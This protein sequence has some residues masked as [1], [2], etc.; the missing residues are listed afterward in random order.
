M[1]GEEK[2]RNIMEQYG[3][4]MISAISGLLVIGLVFTGL[5]PGTGG[6]LKTIGKETVLFG[7]AAG[8]MASEDN[9]LSFLKAAGTVESGLSLSDIRVENP[10]LV[11]E[12]YPVDSIV[13]SLSGQEIG[14]EVTGVMMFSSGQTGA[15]I[16]DQVLSMSENNR[17]I[18]C[19]RS[20]GTYRISLIIEDS[21]GRTVSG[22]FVITAERGTNGELAAFA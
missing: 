5:L 18:I 6:L 12:A 10:L 21:L 8:Y 3:S 19:L 2:M 20:P 17:Q 16:T 22:S 4:A 15:D 13:R 11:N 7:Q 1:K 9:D 14:A